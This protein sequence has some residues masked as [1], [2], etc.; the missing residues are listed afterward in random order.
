MK[1][2]L[3]DTHTFIWW[4]EDS[5]RLS[6]SVREII[7]DSENECWFS[8]VSAWEMAIKISLERLKLAIPLK[9]YI[10]EH[11]AAN[12]FNVLAIDFRHITKVAHLPF[13]HRDPFDRLLI[14]QAMTE[15]MVILS[16]DPAL[17]GYAIERVW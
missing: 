12:N 7:G 16:A 10:P 1:R 5:P 3:L 17:D 4:I 8:L 13:Q 14:A 6:D 11:S 9:R 15:K 2:Y